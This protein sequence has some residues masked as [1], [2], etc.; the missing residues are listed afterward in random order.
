MDINGIRSRG[1]LSENQK[2][3]YPFDWSFLYKKQTGL[4]QCTYC[5]RFIKAKDLTIDHVYPKSLGPFLST[6]SACRKCNQKKDNMLPIEWA[7][8]ISSLDVVL[9]WRMLE[10]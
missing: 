7:L 10:P 1:H 3:F 9:L 8:Y 2:E 5:G 4:F 6:T